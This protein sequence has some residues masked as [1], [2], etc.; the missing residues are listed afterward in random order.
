MMKCE[1]TARE[2]EWDFDGACAP[3]EGFRS[4]SY[5]G[6]ERFTL[7]CWQWTRRGKNGQGVGLKKGK[8]Q[9]RIRG[10]VRDSADVYARARLYCEGRNAQS[11]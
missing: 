3:P 6:F 4:A 8:V 1:K 11:K 10:K 9:Y 2:G 5:Y 7:G